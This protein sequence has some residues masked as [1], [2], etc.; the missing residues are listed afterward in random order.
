MN[1]P[2]GIRPRVT[3]PAG[4]YRLPYRLFARASLRLL[5][6]ADGRQG[7]SPG[8]LVDG[9][10]FRHLSGIPSIVAQAAPWKIG[11]YGRYIRLADAGA[12]I[13][14][15]M[16]VRGWADGTMIGVVRQPDPGVAVGWLAADG[17]IAQSPLRF[18]WYTDGTDGSYSV[19]FG[20]D[21]VPVVVQTP[22]GV[23]VYDE[24]IVLQ[25]SWSAPTLTQF[26]LNGVL[27]HQNAGAVQLLNDGATLRIAGNSLVEEYSD[28]DVGFLGIWRERLG[29]WASRAVMAGRTR[30]A[31]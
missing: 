21:T 6:T 23:A 10:N 24:W 1:Y 2:P 29:G 19:R 18:S 9:A 25:V 14:T 22:P 17:V 3:G 5:I 15:G 27:I 31:A 12:H 13:R 8:Q 16:N 20:H 7:D 30:V 28:L 4:P 11:P 26:H